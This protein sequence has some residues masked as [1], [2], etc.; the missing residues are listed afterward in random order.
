MTPPP[1]VLLH[2]LTSRTTNWHSVERRLLDKPKEATISNKYGASPLYL[3]LYRPVNNY[4]PAHIIELL[5]KLN[6]TALWNFSEERDP[7][8]L[9]CWRRAPSPILRVLLRSRPANIVNT[10]KLISILWSSYEKLFGSSDNLVHHILESGREG[11]EIWMKFHLLL[12]YYSQKDEWHPMHV[13]SGSCGSSTEALELCHSY[14]TSQVQLP[15]C[16]GSLPLHVACSSPDTEDSHDILKLLLAWY[17]QATRIRTPQGK[18]PL[19]EAIIHGKSWAFLNHLLENWPESLTEKYEGLLPFQLAESTRSSCVD[20]TFELLKAAPHLLSVQGGADNT[21]PATLDRPANIS[22]GGTRQFLNAMVS[23]PD[24]WDTALKVISARSKSSEIRV[25]HQAASLPNCPLG[26]LEVATR[27]HPKELSARDSDGNTPLH[28][29]CGLEFAP[30]KFQDEGDGVR[31]AHVALLLGK[32]PEAAQFTNRKGQ[33]P[34]EVAILAGQPLVKLLAIWPDSLIR[35]NRAK[36][37][38]FQLAASCSE[39]EETFHLLRNAPH[40]AAIM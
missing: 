8:K 36:L 29:A 9:A 4:P 32:A 22:E 33:I 17:P 15:D 3:A 13:L 31:S 25:L 39:L 7:L 34:L 30:D 2:Y 26:L 12:E 5:I 19:H 40:L 38:P 24:L 35:K 20:N 6:P 16:A 18:L 14:F 23:S 21:T 1:T 28:I 37:Y 10:A 27:I 11:A